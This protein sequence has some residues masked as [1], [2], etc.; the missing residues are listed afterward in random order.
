M[1]PPDESGAA[2]D[3]AFPKPRAGL[4]DAN[5]LFE[6]FWLSRKES[7]WK[8]STQRFELNLLRNI[9]QLAKDLRNGAYVQM[10]FTEFMQN[11]RG[12]ERPIRAMHIRDRVV[13]R[14]LCDKVLIPALTP[15][16]I[17]DNGASLRGKGIDFTRRRLFC[18]LQR[19]FRRY[20]RDGWVLQIDFSKFF[21]NIPHGPVLERLARIPAVV[22]YLPL[23]RQLLAS[24]RYDVSYGFDPETPFDSAKHRAIVRAGGRQDGSVMLERSVGIG[25]QIS[26]I[27]GIWYPTPIDTWCK[28]VLGLKCYARYMDDVYVIH[29]DR[30]FLK[31]TVLPGFTERARRLGLFV[32]PKK[33]SLRPLRSGFCFLKQRYLLTETGRIEVRCAKDTFIRERRRLKKLRHLA[34]AGRVT[35]E[36]VADGYRSWRGVVSAMRGT[37]RALQITDN[38]YQSL[39]REELPWTEMKEL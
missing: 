6:A 26:Q 2:A 31:E 11:E 33:T 27:F 3:M 39:F 13:Q 10:P 5:D 9:G 30:R 34:D 23:V 25:S 17:H 4:F 37:E 8:A 21:D 15:K 36:H 28:C 19:H 1:M 18:H 35:L 7:Q 24:F 12:K 16:L 29:P 22:P 32:N 14:A 38:L 20:G